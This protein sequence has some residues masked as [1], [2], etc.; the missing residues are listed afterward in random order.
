MKGFCARGD[1]TS[2]DGRPYLP[3]GDLFGLADLQMAI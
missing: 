2:A 1:V 3:A